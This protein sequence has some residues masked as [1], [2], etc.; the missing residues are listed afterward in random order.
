M[1]TNEMIQNYAQLK[2][3]AELLATRGQMLPPEGQQMMDRIYSYAQAT[4]TPS[5]QQQALAVVDSLTA[6]HHQQFMQEQAQADARAMEQAQNRMTT[7]L[8]GGVLTEGHQLAPA[9]RGEKIQ[10]HGKNAV[11]MPM[12]DSTIADMMR[13]L[14][15]PEWGVKDFNRVLDRH[16]ELRLNRDPE[17]ADAYLQRTFGEHAD[18]A[19]DIVKSYN[20]SGLGLAV[21]LQERRGGFEEDFMEDT[22]EETQRR[23]QLT[24]AMLNSASE[25]EDDMEFLADSQFTETYLER[26][27]SLGDVARA[28]VANEEG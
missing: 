26:D 22:P 12:H 6:Q 24:S 20:Q 3:Q 14:D 7:E 2:A 9:A 10:R 23:A 11:N 5:E 25:N 4:L 13:S 28:W 17:A 16:E 27:D 19:R 21:G 8:T 1:L 18:S 15:K